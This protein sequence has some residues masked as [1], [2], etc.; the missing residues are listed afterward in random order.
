MSKLL[1]E[2]E[3]TTKKMSETHMLTVKFQDTS[4][5]LSSMSAMNKWNLCLMT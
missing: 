3:S 1:K 2:S 4:S 5:F